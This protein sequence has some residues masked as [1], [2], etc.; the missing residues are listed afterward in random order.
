MKQL[1]EILLGVGVIAFA[2]L[3]GFIAHAN[4]HAWGVVLAVSCFAGSLV[5]M[6]WRDDIV[7]GIDRARRHI[8]KIDVE[9]GQ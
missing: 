6:Q 1:A 5:A 7:I 9:G 8:A 4:H 2:V 3:G